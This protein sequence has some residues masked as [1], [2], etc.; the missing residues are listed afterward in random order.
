M[1]ID[2]FAI[3]ALD[4]RDEVTALIGTGALTFSHNLLANNGRLGSL[5]IVNETDDD[6]FG[7][8]EELWM[9]SPEHQNTIQVETGLQPSVRNESSPHFRPRGSTQSMTSKRPPKSEFFDES[10]VYPGAVNPRA[11]STWLEG[12]VAYPEA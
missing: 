6:D 12:W 8:N 5:T 3:E 1:I 4:T 11:T 2:S 7:F 9:R 10:A